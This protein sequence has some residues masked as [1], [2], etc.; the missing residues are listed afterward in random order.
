MK[1]ISFIKPMSLMLLLLS[2]LSACNVKKVRENSKPNVIYILADDLGYADL[3]CYG[4]TKFTTPNIDKL[5]AKGIKFTQHYSGSTV[6]APS[7]SALM[8]GQHTGHTYIRG[9]KGHSNEG[10]HPLRTEDF[11]I[12]ELFK[13]N[14][15][16]TGAFGKWGLG[17]P[18]SSGDPIAKG[19][20]EF[21]GYNCQR[22]AHSY[23]PW[24]LY[25]N[26]EK[27]ILDNNAGDKKGTYAP[28]PIHEKAMAFI[29]KHS[30]EPFFLYYPNVI[31][32]AE[33]E[34][35]ESYMEKYRGKYLPEKEFKGVTSKNKRF[36]NGG[37]ASQKESHAAFAG[38]INLM[39]EQVGE[40]VAKIEELG[41]TE[42]TIIMFASDNGPH[43]VGGGDPE[44]F[45]SNGIYRGIK[46]D[47]YE[48]GIRVP[49][50][51]SW[52]E[53]IAQGASSEHMSAFW[54]VLPTMAD[55]LGADQPTNIDGISFLPTL[56]GKPQQEHEYLYW[57]FYER[58]GSQAIRKGNW[59]LVRTKVFKPSQTVTELFD[60]EKDPEETT[61]L[62]NEYPQI[63]SELE[64]LA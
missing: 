26:N 24:H 33:L 5:A 52:P 3:S 58:G 47:L 11:T 10:Q 48:G 56:L 13:Q 38:M 9:N 4:Q 31:P 41:L 2:L 39:D 32:H 45:N 49:F 57:E 21:Y 27:E 34:V 20:D 6:C 25:N 62:S 51:V 35:P 61:D 50:I 37:Y 54:D 18:N 1:T 7:R 29:E 44:Y 43:A 14:G 64:E 63:V 53:T 46:R 22:N 30:D 42:N 59:K 36:R 28:I 17:Y 23:Y 15:Y 19:F 40:I 16:A 12:A 8:T 55:I 60:I